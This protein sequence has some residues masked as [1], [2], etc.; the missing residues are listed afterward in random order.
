MIAVTEAGLV[1]AAHGVTKWFG[2]TTALDGVDMTVPPG[3]VHGLL[4]PNGAGKTTVIRMLTTFR[5]QAIFLK[6]PGRRPASASMSSVFRRSADASSASFGL[7][8]E[9][10]GAAILGSI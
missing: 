10:D 8:S 5:R 2:A 4:G 6:I 7:S 1:V 3:V 9:G